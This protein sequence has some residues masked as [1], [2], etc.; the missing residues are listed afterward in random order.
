MRTKRCPTCKGTGEVRSHAVYPGTH[1]HRP[2]VPCRVCGGSG[3]IPRQH[4]S[5]PP[6]ARRRFRVRLELI[7]PAEGP[8]HA[9]SIARE[10]VS[11]GLCNLEF[12]GTIRI[13]ESVTITRD[14]AIRLEEEDG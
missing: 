11:E 10:F 14:P 8:R 3:K 9:D 4:S 1:A 5:P 6:P 12:N 2:M 13:G 7:I